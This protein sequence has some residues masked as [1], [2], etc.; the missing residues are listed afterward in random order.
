M[1]EELSEKLADTPAAIAC[2]W[3]GK[4]GQRKLTISA[5]G[6]YDLNKRPLTYHW[7]VLRGDETQI[8]IKPRNK[9]GS[10][11][12]VDRTWRVKACQAIRPRL[13]ASSKAVAI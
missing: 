7:V 2:I 5:A 12:R 4:D 9:A 13:R 11:G 1:A 6:S 3:R 8:V 10:V